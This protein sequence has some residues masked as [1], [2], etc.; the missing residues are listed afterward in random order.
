MKKTLA[1][2]LSLVMLAA[3]TADALAEGPKPVACFGFEADEGFVLTAGELAADEARGQVLK[4]EGGAKGASSAK[5]AT[6]LFSAT[7]WAQGITIAF[8]VKPADAEPGIAPLYSFDIV[9]SGSE[10]YIATMDSLEIAINTDGN[11]GKAPYPRVWADP[12]DVGPEAQPELK[13]GEWQHI[14][15]TQAKNGMAIYLNGEL[16]IEP[17]LGPSSA[18]FMLFLDQIQYCYGL[19]LGGWNCMWWDDIGSFAGEYD[20]VYLFNKALTQEEVQ[21]VMNAAFGEL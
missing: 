11:S 15:V 1:L 16:F 21:T 4:L 12:M 19:Q 14:A 10:G 5:L 6:D 3:L 20:D 9:D 8:W 17:M 18:N 13:A 7:D 2:V